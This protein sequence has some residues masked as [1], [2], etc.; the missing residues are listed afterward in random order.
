[1]INYEKRQAII[2][3]SLNEIEFARSFKQGKVKNFKL[4]EDLYYGRIRKD[5]S[6]AARANVDLGEMAG[7]I[8]TTLSKIDNPLTFKFIKRKVSQLQRVKLLNALKAID[9]KTNNW[10]IKDLAGKKQA[11]LYGRA[12]YSYFADSADGY[13]AHLDNVDVYDFLIDPAAGGLDIE[14]AM[15]I[16]DYGVVKTK[17][18]LKDGVKAGDYLR[19]ETQ[20]LIDG[21]G[22]ST[23]RPQEEVNKQNRTQD[24]N[25]WKLTK[26]I[27][28]PD[29]Y[30]FWRWFTT[31]EGERYYLCL[32]ESGGQAIEVCKLDE[33]FKSGLWPYWTW[34]N[35]LDLTEF[36]TPSQ[37]D[38]DREVIM[39]KAT[40]INQMLDNAEQINKP[41]KVVNVGAIE[42]L[43]EL[44]YRR[45]GYI[46]VKKDFDVNR[47]V[48][49]ISVP[50][51]NTPIQVYQLLDGIQEKS[52]GVTSAS[53]GVSEEDKVGI[54]EGNQ[55]EVADRYGL[56]NKSYAFGYKR[57]AQ[58]YEA[59]VREHLVKK[60][61]VD[62]LGPDGV[63]VKEVSRRD[64]FRTGDEYSVTVESSNAELALSE[65]EKRQ[66]IAFLSAQ[67]AIPTMP[68]QKPIQNQQKAYEIQATIAGFD[69]ETIRQLQDTTDF[70]DA[71]LMSEAERD[72]ERILDDEK[73]TPNQAANAAYKQRFVDFM[74]NQQENLEPR[75]FRALADY[76]L[77]LDPI[78]TRNMVRQAN[79]MLANQLIPPVDPANMA[80]MTGA[81][82]VDPFTNPTIA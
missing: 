67:A 69:E 32:C 61:A 56:L 22:N 68:G 19:T 48:Q 46:K 65:G 42:N 1:M 16:G 20:Y 43:A 23:E 58:L 10:D 31:Y 45:D 6:N 8:H 71:D 79:Q 15:Y 66:K 26:E 70:G 44:K 14:R 7:N 59:G 18:E 73:V 24:Q 11:L 57:F 75:Q 13:K 38:Y 4:N 37:A 77:L 54:Y 63:E 47:A 25:V 64:L 28:N 29:L 40:S 51:I 82:P 12:I 74:R 27:G 35:F 17:Q 49:T 33:K 60:V 21:S 80:P 62:I 9:S 55:A 30:K 76:V 78:I 36:W 50:S 34:A 72:I 81:A 41:Q 2:A 53:K 3:Q 39:A 52:S 5:T